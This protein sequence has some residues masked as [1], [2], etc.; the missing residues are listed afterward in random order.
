MQPPRVGGGSKA[1]RPVVMV[2]AA[3]SIMLCLLPKLSSCTPA[4]P[5]TPTATPTEDVAEPQWIPTGGGGGG[6]GGGGAKVEAEMGGPTAAGR[7]E[8]ASASGGGGGGGAPTGGNIMMTHE[9][10]MKEV[11]AEVRQGQVMLQGLPGYVPG[12]NVVPGNGQMPGSIPG[13][14]QGPLPGQIPGGLQGVLP[15]QGQATGEPNLDLSHILPEL[16]LENNTV[17][18]INANVGDVAHLPC[19][20]PQLSTL[21]QKAFLLLQVSW[22]R[23]TDFHIL[24][25]GV[26][27][28]TTDMRFSVLHPEGTDDWTLQIKYAEERDNG[29]YECQMYTG[30]GVLSQFVNL[31]VNRP[32]AAILGPQELHVQEGDTITLVCV[33]QQGKPPFVFWYHGEKM[34]NYDGSR[35]RLS[36]MTKV[37]GTRTH[38]RLTITDARSWDSG[39]YSCIPPNV[40]PSFVIVFV[41]EAGD[42]VAAVQRRGHSSAPPLLCPSFCSSTSGLLLAVVFK[43]VLTHLLPVR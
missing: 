34:V 30:T 23:R 27:T 19:R 29:T 16:N 32:R 10:A 31:H 26:Y 8:T 5:T 25:T 43:V 38:S 15:E 40:E 14:L 11:L 33:I 37:E 17:T 9:E 3:A 24:T 42:T 22:I 41:T 2:A 12:H 7:R 35:N 21:H 36:V 20:F 4:P 39:N 18:E 1:G 28:Y 13:R 6:G